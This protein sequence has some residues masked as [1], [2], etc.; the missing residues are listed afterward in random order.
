MKQ[1]ELLEKQNAM[2][3]C[4]IGLPRKMLAMHGADNMTEFVLHD[5]CNECC[6]NLSRAAYFVDNPDF[7]CIKGVAGFSRD[8][9]LN[10]CSTIWDNPQAFSDCM[11]S[12]SFN[13]K[14][15]SINQCSLKKDGFNHKELAAQL[16]QELGFKN[17]AYCSWSMKHDNE[18]FVIFEKAYPEETFADEYVL[19]GLTL[20]SFCPIF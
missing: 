14:I 5:L 8:E 20:L 6:F 15:R 11:R 12:S 18:G 19:S 17:H 4:L 3:S 13:Q 1:G 7:N 9:V 16:A 10:K 2:L